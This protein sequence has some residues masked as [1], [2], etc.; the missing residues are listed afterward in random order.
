MLLEQGTIIRCISSASP[1][2]MLGEIYVLRDI[3][4]RVFGNVVLSIFSKT[5]RP[6]S[7]SITFDEYNKSVFE[8]ILNTIEIQT[9]IDDVKNFFL[10]KNVD[11]TWISTN[12]SHKVYPCNV[13]NYHYADIH[14]FFNIIEENTLPSNMKEDLEQ[15]KFK[16]TLNTI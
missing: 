13:F 11:I 10:T 8:V 2:L 1:K 14:E 16:Y 9:I 7:F 15:F 12:L 5:S 3:K 4:F 6:K